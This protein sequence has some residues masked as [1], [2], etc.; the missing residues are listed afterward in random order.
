M[1]TSVPETGFKGV[2]TIVTQSPGDQRAQLFGGVQ[3]VPLLYL[4]QGVAKWWVAQHLE[5]GITGLQQPALLVEDVDAVTGVLQQH[6][7]APVGPVTGPHLAPQQLGSQSGY[8]EE[9]QAQPHGLVAVMAPDGHIV[10]LA[11]TGDH[12]Q[13]QLL[14]SSVGVGTWDAVGR[15]L[16]VE[17]PRGDTGV[18]ELRQF[19]RAADGAGLAGWRIQRGMPGDQSPVQI[20]DQNNAIGAKVQVRQQAGKIT[21]FHCSGHYT[22][23]AAVGKMIAAQDYQYPLAGDRTAHQ[24][25][26]DLLHVRALAQP[27]EGVQ[28]READALA[29]FGRRRQHPA[30]GI[31]YMQ[32]GDVTYPALP[33]PDQLSQL[34]GG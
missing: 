21:G 14:Q 31:G 27:V 12:D 11:Q 1:A 32:A 28:R 18:H 13:R 29:R 6:A 5:E 2:G 23:E 10:L 26:D 3:G 24:R 7:A 22:A 30:V 8:Q 34:L 15:A 16:A 17:Q 33:V 25:C 19:P 20:P 9:Q 4:A